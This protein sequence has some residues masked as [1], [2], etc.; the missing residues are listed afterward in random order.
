MKVLVAGDTH[1]SLEHLSRLCVA[2]TDEGAD[3]IIQVGDF[4]FSWSLGALSQADELLGKYGIELWWLDGNHENFDILEI[5][6]GA[7]PDDPVATKT[8]TW[9]TYMPRGYRFTLDGV[10]CMA[11]GGAISID[12]QWR[13]PGVSWWR[14]EAI[15]NRQVDR[16]LDGSFIDI[17]FCHDAPNNGGLEQFFLPGVGPGELRDSALSR[18]ALD[19]VVEHLTPGL[20]VHG[21]YHGR[22][23][24]TIGQV[25]IEGLSC[26]G[27]GADS[28]MMIDTDWFLDG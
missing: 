1:G 14:Q 28:W 3:L 26:A 4:G 5:G 19:K 13:K 25:A 21:H 10:R 27:A 8:G 11:F 17:L 12:R 6:F 18:A 7:T 23:S 16:A 20:V 24:R 2:A 15:T 9:I 22:Y